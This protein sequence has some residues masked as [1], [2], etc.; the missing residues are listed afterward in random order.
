MTKKKLKFKPTRDWVLLPDP[1][2][3]ETDSGII[4]SGESANSLK[5]NVLE[6]LATGPECKWTKV[7]D[8]VMVDPS[9]KGHVIEIDK[10]TYVIVAEFMILG[11][12]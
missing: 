6:V 12:M 7:G 5:T 1:R 9:G 11:V 2:K 8:T 4:L 10:A 3:S